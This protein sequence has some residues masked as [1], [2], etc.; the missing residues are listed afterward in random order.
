MSAE[1]SSST[2]S[3]S[4]VDTEVSIYGGERLSTYLHGTP[5][6]DPVPPP[7]ALGYSLGYPELRPTQ[8][9]V[10]HQ[11]VYSNFIQSAKAEVEQDEGFYS[12]SIAPATDAP[13]RP[14]FL[15]TAWMDG[16]LVENQLLL[17]LVLTLEGFSTTIIIKHLAEAVSP[18]A[19]LNVKDPELI[20][21]M[22]R[23]IGGIFRGRLNPKAQKPDFT[24]ALVEAFKKWCVGDAG[25]LSVLA[26]AEKDSII[27]GDRS[28]SQILA[29]TPGDGNPDIKDQFGYTPEW[30]EKRVD[31]KKWKGSLYEWWEEGTVKGNTVPKDGW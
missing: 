28:A 10:S 30:V 22:Q 31:E 8:P 25:V 2:F 5:T 16:G 9:A 6:P 7:P 1:D 4:S 15:K 26:H 18:S 11:L 20:L 23:H 3:S 12:S 14:D 27:N 24:K 17:V 13:S 29:R 21:D 19:T